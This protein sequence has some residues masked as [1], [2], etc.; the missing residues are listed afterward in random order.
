MFYDHA[1]ARYVSY[2]ERLTNFCFNW[3]LPS[4]RWYRC[5][6][7]RGRR[8]AWSSLVGIG[9]FAF[10]CRF[11][12]DVNYIKNADDD[13]AELALGY[14]ESRCQFWRRSSQRRFRILV[15]YSRTS[16]SVFLFT[17]T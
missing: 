2:Q 15:G 12:F 8:T 11:W 6:E 4:P 10:S 9:R 14:L 5:S 13:A 3:G 7:Q 1:A 16:Y 17:R